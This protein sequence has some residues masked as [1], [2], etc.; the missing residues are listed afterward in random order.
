[1]TLTF[2][3]LTATL[4]LSLCACVT[5]A[6]S[7]DLRTLR[8][9]TTPHTWIGVR[10]GLNLASESV[11]NT[12]DASSTGMRMGFLGGIQVDQWF[13]N[14]WALSVAATM[15]PKG[16]HEEYAGQAKS[17]PKTSGNDNFTFNYIE[18]PVLLRVTFSNG[19]ARPYLFAGPSF[20][21]LS[22]ASEVMDPTVHYNGDTVSPSPLK[23][24]LS[25]TDISIVLGAGFL[26]KLSDHTMFTIDAGYAFGLTN[27]YKSGLPA[28]LVTDNKG[29]TRSLI[30]NSNAKSADFRVAVAFL[31]GL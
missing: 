13:S 16:I 27:I 11:D 19:D 23:N 30:D 14:M 31:Y 24:Y 9:A 15:D 17:H 21:F 28:R 18:V 29:V 7:D 6:Q 1:M 12:V 8:H 3:A 26:D 25:S 22:S 2:R 4:L 5:F 20:G 10:G